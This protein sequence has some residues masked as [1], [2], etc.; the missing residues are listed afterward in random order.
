MDGLINSLRTLPNT[1]RVRLVG[2][3]LV[4]HAALVPLLYLGVSAIVEEGYAELF[5]NSVR[6]FSR[7]T[8]DELEVTPDRDFEHRAAALLDGVML[9]GQVVFTEITDGPRKLHSSIARDAPPQQRADDFY[10]GDHG[11]QVY[12]ISHSVKRGGRVV[13]L[14][15]GFDEG[16][17]LERI[18]AAKH[19]VLTAVLSFTLA[20]IVVSIWLSAVIAHPMVRLQ[21]AAKRV[22]G[23]DVHTRLQMRS[24]IREV[25]DLSHHLES[26]RQA[27]VGANERLASE[28]QE[29]EVSERKR[30]DLERKLLHRERIATIGTLAGGVAHEFNN[31][32]TPILLYSQ[33]ALNETPAD[34]PR[35]RN[36]GRIVSAAH[37]ARSLITRILT[38]SREMDSQG[39]KIFSLRP[40]VEEAL[41]LLR[42][43]VPAN[44]EIVL[45]SQVEDMWVSGDPSLVHQV[46][47]NLGTNAYQAMRRTGGRLVLR[48]W[49]VQESPEGQAGPGRFALLEASDT[50]HGIDPS[51]IAHVFEPFFTTREIGEGTGLG[52][53]VVHGIVTSMGGTITV[54]STVDRGTTFRVY[55]PSAKSP[56]HELVSAVRG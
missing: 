47:I 17:T 15:L 26:M 50:G 27:L 7:L 20:S 19:R 53:S 46:I 52:L 11:D 12:Y 21:E 14:R 23:G 3:V 42:A 22:A 44:I 33:L 55:F 24:S 48:M 56:A 8:A 30:L 41:A 31:I 38:F 29:R 5:V 1:L 25:Q 2:V 13:M 49:Q 16:P 6:S 54:E 37:R 4:I 40:T 51:V 45:D 18:T 39:V 9:T 10:F 28:I 32:L 36:L 35:A 34:S 43:I